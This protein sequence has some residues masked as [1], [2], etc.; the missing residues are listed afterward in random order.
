[1]QLTGEDRDILDGKQG[2]VKAK[3]MR[4]MVK[5]GEIFGA[6]RLLAS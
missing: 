4:T 1:M 3:V 6:T 5:Y 2:D